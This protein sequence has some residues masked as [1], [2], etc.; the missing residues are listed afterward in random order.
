MTKQAFVV[1]AGSLFFLDAMSKRVT[2]KSQSF[3]SNRLSLLLSDA[4]CV[5]F[6]FGASLNQGQAMGHLLPQSNWFGSL[7]LA[8]TSETGDAPSSES[9]E[10]FLDEIDESYEQLM[11]YDNA[12]RKTVLK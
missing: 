9:M 8:G 11:N 10:D 2:H 3:I 12:A 7:A 6:L 1:L 5:I 4:A